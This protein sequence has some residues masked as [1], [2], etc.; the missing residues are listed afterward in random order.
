MAVKVRLKDGSNNVLHPET[1]WSVVL[2]KPSIKLRYSDG[3]HD[4]SSSSKLNSIS[5][6]I[7][8]NS[9]AWD[10]YSNGNQGIVI[11]NRYNALGLYGQGTTP[12][13]FTTTLQSDSEV[14]IAA[15]GSAG[16]KTS[17]TL[18]G[19]NIKMASD[20]TNKNSVSLADYPINWSALKDNPFKSGEAG[21]SSAGAAVIPSSWQ[22]AVFG[23]YVD[24]TY[25][26]HPIYYPAFA[27][28]RLSGE[29]GSEQVSRTS[30]YYMDALGKLVSIPDMSNF[31]GLLDL[32]KQKQ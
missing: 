20:D 28:A 27:I 3:S 31:R 9:E 5:K 17:I 4:T 18:L 21:D 29:A 25:P 13:L 1:D 2:S 11:G 26:A 8:K 19:N 22:G 14:L 23:M 6:Y 12:G 7:G 30:G 24:K 10:T 32:P 15:E 16:K